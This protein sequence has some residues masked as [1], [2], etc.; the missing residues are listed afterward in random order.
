MEKKQYIAPAAEEVAVCVESLL[1]V[2]SGENYTP[3]LGEW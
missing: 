1:V 2:I 3:E